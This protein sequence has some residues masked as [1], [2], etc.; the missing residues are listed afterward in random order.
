MFASP[1]SAFFIAS[2]E[3][4]KQQ[5]NDDDDDDDDECVMK[6]ESGEHCLINTHHISLVTVAWAGVVGDSR[7]GHVLRPCGRGG[8]PGPGAHHS[9]DL[10]VARSQVGHRRRVSQIRVRSETGG[11]HGTF[12]T[13]RPHRERRV[14]I[15]KSSPRLF[16]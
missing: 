5:I 1:L 14:R 11:Q 2:I 3:V 12:S 9:A 13:T 16:K 6:D 10:Q 7:P 8:G 4:L 15:Q